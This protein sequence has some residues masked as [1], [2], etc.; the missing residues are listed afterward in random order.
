MIQP[1]F[2]E[3]EALLRYA[4]QLL[5]TDD[6]ESLLDTIVTGSLQLLQG[7]RGFIVL[8]KGETLDFRVIKNWGIDEYE[9]GQEPISRSILRE[10]FTLQGPLL[11]E[12]AAHDQ[13]FAGAQSVQLL[14]VRSV[15]AAPFRINGTAMGALYLE[16]RSN[17]RFF[18]ARQLMLFCR[19][20]ELST[21]ALEAGTRQLLLRQENALLTNNFLA[22]YHF[23]G[24]VT[25][26]A[27]FAKL[28]EMAGQAAL[29]DL[30][31]LLQGPSGTGKELIAKAIYLNSQRAKKPFITV[32]CGAIS[33]TLLESELF[34]H[35]KGA[36]TGA[37]STKEGLITAAHQG[38]L[39]LDEVSELPKELQVK[40]LRTVQFGEVQPVGSTKTKLLD[41][42]FVSATNR[43]LEEE[44]EEGCFR[45]DLFYR[46][47]T[48]TL[49]LPGLCERRSDILPLFYY[50]LQQLTER[51]NR[52]LPVVSKTLEEVLEKYQWPGNVRELE[53][54]T[55]RLLAL[56]PA[57]LPLT[58]ER[59]STR[60]LEYSEE[61]TKAPSLL[62]LV[63]EERNAIQRHLDAANGNRTRAAETLGVT[64]EGLRKMLK[65]HNLTN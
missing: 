34:G 35:V 39:F 19:L 57:D 42:R 27:R 25:K 12:D 18:E 51:A 43:I 47:N 20:I 21:R 17:K 16:C 1:T 40:L 11:I 59:L 4:Q 15:L 2:A 58:P 46:L 48:V 14:K 44:V 56:T 54:E 36:F 60:V 13:R 32:N 10:V 65:R 31:V 26:N 24:I 7:D 9:A 61:A 41:V 3:Q 52:P 37:T 23:P 45:E 49:H 28:L 63:E 64:R 62:P 22:R 6:Y 38:T 5:S 50:F 53:N 55:K 33:P 30:P 8:T 29:S